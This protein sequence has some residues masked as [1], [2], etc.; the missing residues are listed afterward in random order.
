[1]TQ[2]PESAPTHTPDPGP[3]DTGTSTGL[4]PN[5]SG[6]LAYL[7]GPIT[8]ILFLLLEKK[9]NF[10]RF[11]AAQSIGIFVV[12]FGLSIVLGVLSAILTAI[13]VLGWIIGIV[14][15]LLSLLIGLGG[16]ILWIFLMFQA[17]QHKEW[18]F[19]WVGREV[20]KMILKQSV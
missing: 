17:F 18:E 14:F 1:M 5:V 13:P 16:F 8:G 20:R 12:L 11:H 15:F 10:V 4:A 9:S 2:G 6:A 19:P 7:L 3:P